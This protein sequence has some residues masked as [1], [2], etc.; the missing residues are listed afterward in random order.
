MWGADAAAADQA[1]KLGV[2]TALMGLAQGGY[3]TALGY[4]FSERARLALRWV[5][6]R[7]W[8]RARLAVGWSSTDLVAGTG[9][10]T[11][12]TRSSAEAAMVAVTARLTPRWSAGVA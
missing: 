1:N 2:S 3:S 9:Q 7:L 10:A 8:G 11:D 4:N 12:R 6:H 5:V